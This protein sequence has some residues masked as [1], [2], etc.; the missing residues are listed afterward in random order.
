APLSTWRHRSG[1]ARLPSES[2]SPIQCRKRFGTRG[3]AKRVFQVQPASRR[4][5]KMM[6]SVRSIARVARRIALVGAVCL[7]V[8]GC[9]TTLEVSKVNPTAATERTGDLGV[10]VQLVT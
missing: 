8:S 3:R 1:A 7:S 10:P 2:R 6:L 9:E 5:E 4:Q